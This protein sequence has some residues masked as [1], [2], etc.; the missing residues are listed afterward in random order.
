[1]ER[2]L[3]VWRRLVFLLRRSRMDRELSEEL[4]LHL[5]MKVHEKRESGMG[6]HEARQTASREFGNAV[7]LKEVSRDMWGF[8]SVEMLLQDV[9]FGLRILARNPGFT[10]VVVLT[11]TLGIGATTAIFSVVYGVLLRPLPY[12]QP[13]RIVALQEVN[14]HGGRMNFADPNFED[15][16]GQARSLEGAAEYSASMVSVVGASEPTRTMVAEVSKD[17]FPLLRVQPALGRGFT[18]EEARFGAAPAALVSHGYW[19]QYLG[20]AADFGRVKLTIDNRSVSVVG[21]LPP[22]F[23]FPS[24]SDI[25]IPREIEERLPSRTA[26]NWHVLARLR[27]GVTPAQAHSEL[28]AI[29]RE[30]TRQYGRDT[31]MADVSVM[32]LQDYLTI[33]VRPALYVLLGAVGFLLLVACAN[34][35][36]LLLAHATAREKELALRT[37]LGAGRGRLLGQFLTEALLI[38]MSGGLLGVIAARWGVDALLAMAPGNLPNLQDVS[39]NLEVLLF[40]LGVSMAVAF[41]L[42]AFTTWR[43]TARD[44]RLALGERSQGSLDSAGSLRMGRVIAAAQLAV[45]LILLVGAGLL[46]RSLLRVLSVDPG[47]R[48]DHV[49]TVDL[50][51]PDVSGDSEKGRRIVFLRNLFAQFGALPGVEHVGG[52]RGLP[53]N[54]DLADG[55]FVIMNPNDRVP[56]MEEFEKLF[57]NSAR[58]GEASYCAADAS[59]FRALGI[60]LLRGRMFDERDTIDSPHVALI[61]ESLARQ[62]WPA[63][64][65]LGQTIE[66]GNMDGDPRFLTIVGVVGDVRVASLESRP[67]PIIYSNYLQRPQMTSYR[68]T[69]VLRAVVPPQ[70]LIAPAR[71][72]LQSLAPDVPPSFTTFSRVFQQSLST[73]RFHLALVGVFAMAALMLAVAGTYGVTAYSVARR[74]REFGVRMALG[75]QIRDVLRLVLKQGLAT[76]AI[77]VILGMGGSILL[78]RTLESQLFGITAT[79]PLTF[80]AVAVVLVLASLLAGFIPARRATKVDPMTALRCE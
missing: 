26:H 55:G 54:G 48:T 45:T 11:L 61:S 46:G 34:V 16:R 38:S 27:E 60:P 47:F 25:W 2:L 30:L 74:T 69:V 41:V 71:S 22:G 78:T 76:T 77:G 79:D 59:Y 18:P 64:D 67:E 23:R 42:G 53:L 12:F 10:A 51:L 20:G 8:R 31:M 7:L 24:D 3:R 6:E 57:Q 58:T 36:N 9:R 56:T 33:R 4:R 39:L 70:S 19:Q 21:I 49:L 28:S 29:A 66:F 62:R 32:R 63:I 13:D 50:A 35:V 80:L 37:A 52:T 17:F 75:A 65:P 14:E 73:R 40:A 72:I 44:A 68:F 43:A 15:V 1:M 5:E